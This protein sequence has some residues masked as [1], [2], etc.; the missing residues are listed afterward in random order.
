[1]SRGATIRIRDAR[2]DELDEVA[3]AMLAAYQEYAAPLGRL[4]WEAYAKDI[5]DVRGRL[6]NSELI[7]ADDGKR[8]AG[9]VTFYPDGSPGSWP[10][11]WS[12]IRLVAV[13][14]QDRGLG[15]G[16]ALTQECI[17]RSRERGMAAIGLRNPPIMAVARGMYAR[18]GFVPAP[19]LD[20]PTPRDGAA[21]AYRLDL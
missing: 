11:G 4:R 17:R 6:E 9:A 5:V 2:P 19:E 16:R 20:D 10:V 8:I 14:P 1:M 15:I 13:H 21:I 12:S 3:E 18:M 7:V